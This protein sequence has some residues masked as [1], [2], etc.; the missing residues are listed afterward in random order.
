MSSLGTINRTAMIRQLIA[1]AVVLASVVAY[2]PVGACSGNCTGYVRD[3]SVVIKDGIYYRF[4]TNGGINIA[5]A[6]SIA[7]PWKYIGAALPHG[8]KIQLES[9][10]DSGVLWAPDVIYIKG[11]YYLTY[12]KPGNQNRDSQIGVATSTTLEPGSWTDHGSVG[13]PDGNWLR[14]DSNILMISEDSTPLL[15][16]GSFLTDI[17]QIEMQTPPLSV[18]DPDKYVH[19][20]QNLTVR[21]D[22]S[23]T[24][25]CEGSYQFMWTI[26][27]KSYY[28]LFFSSGTCCNTPPNLPPPGE[29]Y[30][31][32]VCRSDG[33]S[34]PFYGPYGTSCL[35][36]GGWVVLRSHDH[37]YAPGGQGVMW[38]PNLKSVI[39]Y[40]HYFNPQVGYNRYT[41]TQFGWNKLDFS[42][43]WPLVVA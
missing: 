17:W 30:K 27:G 11:K 42:T 35:R 24:G 4:T 19:L 33:P 34:G 26:A 15:S 7:G 1:L 25:P 12:T 16:W 36:S 31:I 13:I 22:G 28:Y 41:Q 2:P 23:P 39:M 43:G 3:P 18:L 38:D 40:Y 10:D 29:V 20:E 37:V 21:P 9:L 14:I 6:S 5:T 32:M 8:S